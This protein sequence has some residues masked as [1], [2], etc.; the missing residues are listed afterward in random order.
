MF[1]GLS[2]KSCFSTYHQS[3]GV[4]S[5]GQL[6]QVELGQQSLS[7]RVHRCQSVDNHT[8]DGRRLLLVLNTYEL[9]K[10]LPVWESEEDQLGS[11]TE[12]PG[13]VGR[14]RHPVGDPEGRPQKPL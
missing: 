10:V 6:Q 5:S 7:L 4:C 12:H 2:L 9:Q 3:A 13:V 14:Q 8:Q 11:L 1:P